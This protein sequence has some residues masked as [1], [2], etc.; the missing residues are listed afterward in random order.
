MT[1]KIKVLLA[2]LILGALGGC[3]KTMVIPEEKIGT[4]PAQ[5]TITSPPLKNYVSVP[6]MRS[7][8]VNLSL[9]AVD[10]CAEQSS[11]YNADSKLGKA[12]LTPSS[13]FQTFTIPSGKYLYIA[14]N[15]HEIAGGHTSTCSVS[16]RF[17]V[18]PNSKYVYY[19]TPHK[20]GFTNV[21]TCRAD[22]RE[23]IL[24]EGKEIEISVDSFSHTPNL[25]NAQRDSQDPSCTALN[26]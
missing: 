13:S 25:G 3:A 10:R 6:M 19:F 4:N 1:G 22:L 14:A 15:S 11:I 5:I 7:K 21:V 20:T 17:L 23:I 24:D 2:I 26:Q 12:V 18:K 8:V 9:T 16:N